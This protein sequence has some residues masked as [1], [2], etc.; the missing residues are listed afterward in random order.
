MSISFERSFA[1]HPKSEYWNDEK[2]GDITPRDVFKSSDKKCWFDCEKCPHYFDIRLANIKLGRWC[3][4]CGNKKICNDEN[5][6]ECFNKSFASHPKSNCWNFEK[7]GDLNPRD[8]FKSSNK[9]FWFD[10]DK[11]THYFDIRLGNIS[12]GYWCSYCANQKLCNDENCQDC[13]NKSFASNPRSEYWDYEKNGGIN[14][15]DVFNSSGKNYYFNCDI[16]PHKFDCGLNSINNGTWCPYCAIPSRILCND[17]NCQE[18]FNKSF[19][20][21]PKS[22]YWNDEKNGGINPRD[23]FKST[24]KNFWFDCNKNHLFPASLSNISNNNRWCPICI[25]KTEQKIFEKI[26]PIYPQIIT[27]FKKDWCKNINH[28]PFDFCISDHNII[29]ELDG[30]QHFKQVRDWKTPEEQM[31]RDLYKEKQARE[32]GYS[33]IRLLQEDVF[34]DTYDWF[35]E[36]LNNI[37]KIINEKPKIQNIYMCKNNEYINYESSI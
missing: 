2:N 27:Q 23:V 30:R 20:S 37:K 21:H 15:R 22:E 5:C 9:K 17:E 16:C 35:N 8:V 12:N 31:E 6:K 18:C 4:Y 10:C 29:I 36:L 26:Q 13:F 28:L 34:D 33:I 24:H 3:S 19:A 1:S 14:P 7:N 25:N 32:N 11:C